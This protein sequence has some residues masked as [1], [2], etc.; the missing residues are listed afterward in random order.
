MTH[1]NPFGQGGW[2]RELAASYSPTISSGSG[3]SSPAPSTSS[4]NSSASS[5]SG[6]VPP[7]SSYGAL[8]TST[9]GAAPQSQHPGISEYYEFRFE[10][11]QSGTELSVKLGATEHFRIRPGRPVAVVHDGRQLP[12]AKI[13]WQPTGAI[14]ES[15]G[16]QKKS[17]EVI[18]PMPGNP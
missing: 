6:F 17:T 2:E 18:R 3:F 16:V 5:A 14:V 13:G 7:Q 9:P 12:V 10:S 15:N 4:S 8:P 11:A 1:H